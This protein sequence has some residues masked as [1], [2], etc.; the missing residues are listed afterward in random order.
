MSRRLLVLA[1]AAVA[2][3]LAA[4]GASLGV[5]VA[6]LSS[7]NAGAGLGGYAP[8]QTITNG[9]Q[10]CIPQQVGIWVSGQGTVT[11]VPDVA[12]L[13][14][15]VEAQAAMV[16]QA[17]DEA[18]EAMNRVMGALR[19][20][21]VAERDIK[22]QFFNIYPVRRWIDDDREV[23][24]GYRVTNMVTAK[25]RDVGATGAIIDSVA[26]AGGDLTRIQGVSFTVDDPSQYYDEARVEAIADAQAK[27]Q[28][29]AALAGVGLGRP[30]YISEGGVFVPRDYMAM[31]GG[32]APPTP[33]TPGEMEITLTVQM[34]F[35]IQ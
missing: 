10:A 9:G 26:E 31:E 4:V 17:M 35:A 33:I 21:G 11:V 34:G 6:A 30:F 20:S 14:L 12:I 25:I 1:V 16:E 13:Q 3:V 15:G 8:G 28:H 32:A 19:A 29:L 2:L 23:L 18:A 5:S 22:T 24:I 27:A 7:A